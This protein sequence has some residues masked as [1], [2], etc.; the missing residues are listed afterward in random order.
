MQELLDTLD[1]WR[2]EGAGRRPGRRR[3]D[4]RLAPRGRRAP[5]CS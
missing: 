3:P 5:S 1:G 4:V 2:A